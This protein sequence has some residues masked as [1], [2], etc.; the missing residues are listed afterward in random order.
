MHEDDSPF[1]LDILFFC[2]QVTVKKKYSLIETHRIQGFFLEIS[3][4]KFDMSKKIMCEIMVVMAS[5]LMASWGQAEILPP[6]GPPGTTVTIS[7]EDFGAFQSTQENKVEFNGTPAL[8][9]LWES[10]FIMAKVP[11]QARSG[12]VVVINGQTRRTIG[13]FDVRKPQI[14]KLEPSEAEAGSILIVHGENFSK[15]AGSR[16]PNTM[17][18]VNQVLIGGIR[19]KVRKWRPTKVEVK[20]PANARTGKV[21]VRLASSDPLPD[22]SCCAEVKYAMSNSMPLTVVPL[23]TFQPKEGPVGSKV[24]FSGQDFGES[25]PAGAAVLIGEKPSTI[26]RWSNRTIVVHVP[27]NAT[28]GAVVLRR[29]RD[30]ESRKVGTF[31]VFTSHV[32]RVIPPE[33]PIGSLVVIRGEHFGV[34]SESGSIPYAFDFD[35][36]ANGVEIGGVRAIIH[37]WLDNQIY[38]W[39]PFSAKSGPMIIKRGATTPLPDGTCCAKKEIVTLQ[40]GNFTVITPHVDSYAPT[41]AG[42][43]EIVTITGSGFGDFIKIAEP[44]QLAV[45]RKAHDWQIYAPGANVSRSEVMINGMAS[46]VVS[47]TNAQIKVRVPRRHVFGL[48]NP[49]GFKLDATKG[50][51]VV[52]RGSWDAL[53]NGQCCTDKKWISVEAGPFTVLKR[54]LP[55]KSYSQNGF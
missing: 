35:P 11:L 26:A 31:S 17:F 5:T 22:G 41:A 4:V 8:I 30:G 47:W 20:I 13:V 52:K 40:A 50:K 7:G 15:T 12:A 32:D 42:I 53:E 29:G 18:G 49:E 48:A 51:L 46:H 23:V 38:F 27:L 34:Y 36:G 55:D 39:V 2:F 24:I 6:L 33:A 14:T 45:N 43:D 37:R 16:D 3:K 1:Y 21:E 25:Q 19:A 44:T 9:Q 10:D 28:S 54:G